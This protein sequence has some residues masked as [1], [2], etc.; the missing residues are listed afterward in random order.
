MRPA[1]LT[2]RPLTFTAG[3]FGGRPLP[4]TPCAARTNDEALGSSRDYP[5]ASPC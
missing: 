2:L 5:R 4:E 1:L 3:G